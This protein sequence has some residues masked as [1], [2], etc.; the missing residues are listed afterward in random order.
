MVLRSPWGPPLNMQTEARLGMA[1]ASAAAAS[2]RLSKQFFAPR[3]FGQIT[4][5]GQPW[6]ASRV[7]LRSPWGPPLN[8]QTEARLGFG[9]GL[10][11]GVNRVVSAGAESSESGAPAPPGSSF[12]ANRGLPARPETAPALSQTLTW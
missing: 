12:M 5:G 9:R 7:V 6:G 10:S 8:V 3:W 2:P 1:G 4:P 11:A